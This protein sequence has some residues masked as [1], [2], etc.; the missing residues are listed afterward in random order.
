[1]SKGISAKIKQVTIAA[2]RKI[3][4]A[5]LHYLEVTLHT[6]IKHITTLSRIEEERYVRL[7]RYTVRSLELV[8]PMNDGGKSLLDVI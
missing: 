7:D 1:M 6:Q 8:H 2:T 3:S 5:V 4:G